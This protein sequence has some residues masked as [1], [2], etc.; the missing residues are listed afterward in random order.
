MKDS[1]RIIVML[2]VIVVMLQI[3]V[4][5]LFY[6]EKANISHYIIPF[7]VGGMLWYDKNKSKTNS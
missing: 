4:T 2:M 1:V 6:P 3:S 7:L 5:L